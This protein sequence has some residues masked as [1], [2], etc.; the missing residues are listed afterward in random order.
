MDRQFIRNNHTLIGAVAPALRQIEEQ[1]QPASTIRVS[2]GGLGALHGP[3]LQMVMNRLW[4]SFC[5]R[6]GHARP[7]VTIVGQRVYL[8]SD[9]LSAT[10]QIEA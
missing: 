1:G 8:S 6:H 5:E 9:A 10:L 4:G 2:G 3:T 7:T